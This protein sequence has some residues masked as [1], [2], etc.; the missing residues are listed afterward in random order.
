MKLKL[1]WLATVCALALSGWSA[2]AQTN[3]TS[4]FYRITAGHY[5][6]CCGIAG[7]FIYPL[8]N[9][10]QEFVEL[11]VDAGRNTAQMTFL[12]EDMLTVFESGFVFALS[13]GIVFPD[14]IQFGDP[15]PLPQPG[16]TSWSYTISNAA[17][18]LQIKGVVLTPMVGADLPNAFEHTNVVAMLEQTTVAIDRLE[19]EG[20]M[21][22]FHFTGPPPYLYTVESSDSLGTTNWV[23]VASYLAKIQTVDV[24]VTNSFTNANARFFRVRQEPCNCR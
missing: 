9:V 17:G 3:F 11:V 19:R 23:P 6:E 16:Q 10:D 12:G 4:G 15:V 14:Y 13:N 5:A 24:V 2:D 1:I 8:P 21:M 20:D 22:H 7:P 18:G